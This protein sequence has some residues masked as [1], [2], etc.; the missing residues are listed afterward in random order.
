MTNEK[1][2]DIDIDVFY[3]T[4][5]DHYVIS[6]ENNDGS[7]KKVEMITSREGFTIIRDA[8][9]RTLEKSEMYQR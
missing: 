6:L 1:F 2:K 8:M 9:T 7:G 4:K 3:D 5:F